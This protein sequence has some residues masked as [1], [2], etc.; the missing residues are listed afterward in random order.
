MG[1]KKGGRWG[2]RWRSVLRKFGAG[3]VSF[4]ASDSFTLKPLGFDAI[5]VLY[6]LLPPAEQDY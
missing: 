3:G 6:Q 4:I 1:E 2:A 5:G